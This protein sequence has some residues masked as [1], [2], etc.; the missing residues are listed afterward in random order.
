MMAMLL[1]FPY[2]LMVDGIYAGLIGTI[3]MVT[4]KTCSTVKS[5]YTYQNPNVSTLIKELDIEQRMKLVQ[6]VINSIDSHSKKIVKMKLDDMEKTQIFE[7]VGA[8]VDLSNDPIELCLLSLNEVIQDIN[9]DLLA[10]DRKVGY[11]NTKWFSSWRT[12]NVK[13]LLDIL[14]M[15]SKLLDLRFN[16]L[17]KIS[18]FLSKKY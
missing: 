12:L 15:H 9:N 14:S 18:S 5:I 11:H 8:D 7:L 16:D 17:A 3:S 6:A 10:I 1:S 2:T 4:I 13:S